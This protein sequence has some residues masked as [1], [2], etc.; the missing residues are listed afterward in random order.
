MLGHSS[1]L[2]LL[3]EALAAIVRPPEPLPLSKWMAKNIV[4][5]D[6]PLAGSL[7]S[8]AGA[9]YLVEIADCLDES[10]PCNLV[11]VRKSQQSGASILGLGWCLY[12]ADREPANTLYAVP[13]LEA[14]RDLNGRKLGPLIEA[15]QKHI[16]RTVILPQTSRSGAGSTWSEKKFSGGYLALANA[17]AVMDLSSNTTKKGIKD[18]LSKW[19]DIP[20]FG[21]P[22][23]LFFGR[24]T[25]FR[26]TEDYK[27]LEISTPEVDTGDEAGEKPGHCRIDRSFKKS[28]R[29]FWHMPCPG[30][31][32]FIAH[33]PAR[34]RI[35][36]DEPRLSRYQ[37]GECD[38]LISDSERV[39]ALRKGKWIATNPEGSHPGFHID[40]F[41]SLMMSYKAIAED[42]KKAEKGIEKDRK[43]L[44]NLVFG[45]P[46]RF[47]G[48]A[49]DHKRLLERRE[50]GLIQG[51]VPPGGLMLVAGVDVQMRGVWV[52]ITAHGAD[53]QSWLVDRFYLDGDTGAP[54]A[55]VF[56]DL[57][58][59]TVDRS[60]PD[61][62]GR[63]RQI[64]AVAIDTGYRSHV[65]YS[66]V[67]NNQRLHPETGKDLILAVD[68]RKGWN[69]P[70]IGTPKLVDIDLEGRKVQQGCKLWPVGTWSLKSTF[71][72]DLH[73][74][75]LKSG[76]LIDPPGYCHFGMWVDEGYFKQVTAEHLEDI[77]VRGQVTGRRWAASGENHL[78]DCRIYALA[79]IE[80]LGLSSMTPEE[81][82][83]LA[84]ARGLP[85][86]LSTVD[87]FTPKRREATPHEGSSGS[88]RPP[89]ETTPAIIPP[90]SPPIK[91]AEWF[92]DRATD[93]WF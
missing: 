79:L 29:R 91:P 93:D 74:Q 81:W 67:R 35:N 8:T 32:V 58:A 64:D 85:D 6:G 68:G 14:L 49:P 2:R 30:C 72:T 86:E 54:D 45:R 78:L 63:A 10:H 51:R 77:I 53:R 42:V 62:F 59:R 70:A 89:E 21:D 13:G 43:D 38:Y 56:A 90:T 28:D 61:A 31:G 4:L 66:F 24:F 17:N 75:G 5:V 1:A 55:P 34:L 46:Y 73:K 3:A 48:E 44:C 19:A 33:D 22:E 52:E 20:G 37:C 80:Y 92:D 7:W 50:E 87:L 40:A 23:T 84:R 12:I 11:T 26:A 41:V 60:F 83:A 25:A 88:N 39:A 57:L 15:W 9:P 18:E 65:V 82:A 47:R 69:L 76:A 71:Y 16:K 36:Y 27:I